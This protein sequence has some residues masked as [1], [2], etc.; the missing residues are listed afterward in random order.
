MLLQRMKVC[1]S[2][3]QCFPLTSKVKNK[4]SSYC[5]WRNH[6]TEMAVNSAKSWWNIDFCQYR[7]MSVQWWLAFRRIRPGLLAFISTALHVLLIS[8]ADAHCSFCR[9]WLGLN[10][11]CLT[12]C[13]NHVMFAS[14]QP[15]NCDLNRGIRLHCREMGMIYMCQ[16]KLKAWVW[17]S[18]TWLQVVMSVTIDYRVYNQ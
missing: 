15:S 13:Y 6:G 5:Q 17:I 16:W 8:S 9:K 3:G 4:Q 10:L 7:M 18:P 11:T 14:Q 1:N 2:T 12:A